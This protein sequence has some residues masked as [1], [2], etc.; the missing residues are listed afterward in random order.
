MPRRK[1]LTLRVLGRREIL[2]KPIR[3]RAAADLGFDIEFESVDGIEGI[4]RAVIRPESFDIYH[5]W[6]TVDLIWTARSIQPIDVRRIPAW[7]E[8]ERLANLHSGDRQICSDMFRQLY[9]Q[10]DGRLG[11]QVT[12]RVSM[13]PTI[14]GMDGFGYL[15]SHRDEIMKGEP[16]SWAWLLD[17]RWRG[18]V[19]LLRDPSLGM[20]EAA[21]AA[22]A[23]GLVH[24]EDITN[25]S[26]EEIDELVGILTEKKRLGHF[27]G[28]WETYE[29]AVRLMD[30]GGAAIQSIFSPAVT[31]LRRRGID[32][33]CSTPAEGYRGWHSDLCISSR[34]TGAVLD[35]AYE[36]LNWWLEGWAGAVLARQGYYMS[37]RE[38]IRRYLSADEWSYWYEGEPAAGDL[39]D[40]YG[41]VCVRAGERRDGGS[42]IERMSR[43]RV[44]NTFMDDH[45][46][47]ARRWSEFLAA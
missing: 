14:H 19:G 6:H 20:M 30:R 40:P 33:V 24:F 8:V 15:R 31:E 4:Q 21:L 36:Y 10:S 18:R 13:V 28:L 23:A 11:P 17:D 34:S 39:P 7:D 29:D 45:N 44:W 2:L 43:V 41:N 22:D 37:V 32:V 9:V 16:E 1:H 38:K 47:L 42:Y 3:E 26:I 35:A 12:D 25:L 27:R 46:Y 5:Q